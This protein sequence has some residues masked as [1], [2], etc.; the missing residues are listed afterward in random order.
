MNNLKLFV[1]YFY[2]LIISPII[3]FIETII[4]NIMDII[5][6]YKDLNIE[7]NCNDIIE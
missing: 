4:Y 3:M 5:D 6:D 1:I 7:I 2:S